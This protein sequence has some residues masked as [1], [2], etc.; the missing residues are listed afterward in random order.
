MRFLLN[1]NTPRELGLRLTDHGHSC[2]HVGDIGMAQ[3]SD[4]EI[5]EEAHRQGEVI[6]THDLDYGHLLAFS[7]ESDPSVIILRVRNTQSK[8]LAG[9]IMRAWGEIEAALEDGAIVLLED[10][11]TRVRRLPIAK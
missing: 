2:R 4:T 5:V 1:M 10:A 9:R 11:T 6:I 8:N 7:G 3:A